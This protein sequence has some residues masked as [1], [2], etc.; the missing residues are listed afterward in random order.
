[1]ATVSNTPRRSRHEGS[2]PHIT[3]MPLTR[4]N[5]YHHVNWLNVFFIIII[6]LY[7]CIAAWWTPLRWET[8]IWAVVYYF[9][10][11]LGITAGESGSVLPPPGGRCSDAVMFSVS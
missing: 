4:A 10:T 1:M 2:K 6:P 5:W 8:A 3:E 7:G 9:M 11:G